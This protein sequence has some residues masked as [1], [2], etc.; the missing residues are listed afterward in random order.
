MTLPPCPHVEAMSSR[1]VHKM[2][3]KLSTHEILLES[4]VMCKNVSDHLC[5]CLHCVLVLDLLK[6]QIEKIFMFGTVTW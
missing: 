3:H 2:I 6:Y 1:A 5:L 4:C